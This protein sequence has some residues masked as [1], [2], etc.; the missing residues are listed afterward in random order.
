VKIACFGLAFKP[1]IDDLR[2]SPAVE[3]A[4]LIAD[5]HVGETLVVEP[6]VEQLPKSLVGHV[7]LKE[8]PEALQQADVIVMLVDHKQFKAIKPEEITQSWI[9]DTKGVWR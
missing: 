8:L 6:N 1:N 7:T 4:H 9:V 3:V 5:W 2:E